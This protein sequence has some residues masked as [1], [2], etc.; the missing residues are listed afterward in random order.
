MDADRPAFQV[1]GTAVCRISRCRG[2]HRDERRVPEKLGIAVKRFPYALAQ[3]YVV[4]ANSQISNSEP[5]TNAAERLD[6]NGNIFVFD[7]ENFSG[8]TVPFLSASVCP[9]GRKTVFNLFIAIREQ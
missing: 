8:W 9:S 1:F 5:R 4:N 3:R 6:Q 7:F 2:S